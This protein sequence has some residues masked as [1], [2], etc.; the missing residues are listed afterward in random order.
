[1][2]SRKRGRLARYF[3]GCAVRSPD[4]QDACRKRW[5]QLPRETFGGRLYSGV[6][7]AKLPTNVQPSEARSG[8]QPGCH[9]KVV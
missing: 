5:H 4:P 9:P 8:D 6:E 2:G 3:R 1:M 7:Q